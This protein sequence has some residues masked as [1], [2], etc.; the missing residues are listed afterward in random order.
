MCTSAA[1]ALVELRR[2]EGPRLARQAEMGLERDRVQGHEAVDEAPDLAGAAE[3]AHVGPAV[4]DDGEVA[5]G[6]A[7]DL[8]HEGHRLA[9]RAPAADP[10]RHAVAQ[11]GD[12]LRRRHAL[13]HGASQPAEWSGM[14]TIRIVSVNRRAALP[15][16]RRHPTGSFA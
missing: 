3:Q 11:L 4:A 1:T 15:P 9:P 14:I 7:Q 10:E 2:L 5:Q 6:R 13:V 12:D 16:A 8:A